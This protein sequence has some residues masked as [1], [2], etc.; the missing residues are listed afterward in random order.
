MDLFFDQTT[1]GDCRNSGKT[2]KTV[3]VS[4]ILFLLCLNQICLNVV[5]AVLTR[6]GVRY[7]YRYSNVQK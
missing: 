5:N 3:L 4:F 2:N 6:V 1:A 7:E